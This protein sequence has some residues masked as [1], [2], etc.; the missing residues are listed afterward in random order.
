MKNEKKLLL[1]FVRKIWKNVEKCEND[2]N[3]SDIDGNGQK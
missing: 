1:D 3:G 2:E